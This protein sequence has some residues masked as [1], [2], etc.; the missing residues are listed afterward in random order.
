MSDLTPGGPADVG[1]SSI[2]ALKTFGTNAVPLMA[3]AAIVPVLGVPQ[4]FAT[5]P[6]VGYVDCL[7]LELSG[8]SG[9]CDG[10]LAP[11]TLITLLSAV[12]FVVASVLAQFAVI[13]MSLALADGQTM[14]IGA[15]YSLVGTSSFMGSV[16]VAIVAVS[17]GLALCVLPGLLALFFLQLAPFAALDRRSTVRD[18]LTRSAQ[19][20]GR[21]P[22]A[23]LMLAAIDIAAYVLGGLFFGVVT[24]FTLPFA[25]LVTAHMYRQFTR[26]PII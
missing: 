19:L 13:R 20:V 7:A 10:A 9:A 1:R 11:G 18:A 25:A 3:T 12:A 24:L 17:I 26:E 22:A 6:L 4:Q 5:R 14:S 21:N 23:A 15:A 16:L 2:W 8:T